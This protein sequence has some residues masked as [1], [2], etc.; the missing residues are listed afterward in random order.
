MRRLEISNEVMWI[1]Q[2]C[3]Q[4]LLTVCINYSGETAEV[5]WQWG[6]QLLYSENLQQGEPLAP[7]QHNA[8]EDLDDDEFRSR[9]RSNQAFY[10]LIALFI[11]LR[12]HHPYPLQRQFGLQVFVKVV[13]VCKKLFQ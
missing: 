6:W 4:R 8:A 2:V 1:S 11:L 9:F 3:E 12:R 5:L 13:V 10:L 7:E